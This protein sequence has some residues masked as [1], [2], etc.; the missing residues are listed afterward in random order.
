M[1]N[2]VL[3]ILKNKNKIK[4]FFDEGDKLIE[5]GNLNEA[6]QCYDQILNLIPENPTALFNKGWILSQLGR[7]EEALEYHEKYIKKNQD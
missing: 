4:I 3:N 1:V 6:L 7:F 5:Q 2:V